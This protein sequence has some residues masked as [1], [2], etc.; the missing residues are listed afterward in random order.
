MKHL[1]EAYRDVTAAQAL[2]I[3][4]DAPS[5]VGAETPLTILPS[6]KH[7]A[8]VSTTRTSILQLPDE[9]LVAII[10]FVAKDLRSGSLDE[11]EECLY[12]WDT[13]LWNHHHLK[14]LSR[15]CRRFMRI[16]QPL[17]FRAI[18]FKSPGSPYE[19]APPSRSVRTLH[20]TL[21]ETPRFQ[22]YCRSLRIYIPDFDRSKTP[23]KY[24]VAS[25]FAHWLTRT[26]CLS[27]HGGFQ[28]SRQDRTCNASTWALIRSFVANCRDVEHLQLSR[29]SFGLYLDPIFKWLDF[30]NLNTLSVHGIS[31]WEHGKV[32][33]EPE[34]R[35]TAP[36]KSLI[37]S[38]YEEGPEATSLFIQWPAV[39]SH[40]Q[41]GSFYNNSHVMD[42]SMFESWLLIHKDTL[43]HVDIGYLSAKGSSGPFNATLFPNLEYLKL[44]R[45]QT[46]Q[47][48]VQFKADDANVLGPKLGTFCWGFGIFDQHSEGWLDF[49]EPE[50]SWIRDLVNA[51][52]ACK[53]V[54]RTVEIQF[55]PDQWDTDYG[56]IYPWDL[57]DRLGDEVL[58]PKGMNLVYNDPPISRENWLEK[59]QTRGREGIH[60]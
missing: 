7:G 35:R 58:R 48:S 19:T 59:L 56:M 43:K 45:W 20:H 33:L 27:I 44:S 41:F 39:L 21:K 51:A 23:H 38:D 6:Q 5:A 31:K 60:F 30:P 9:L 46:H 26:R 15:V 47:G 17:L 55:S 54:L 12:D 11:C 57:M 16:A 22:Q 50:S 3:V 52:V 40:F 28:N 13:R 29:E 2:T 34:K 4:H 25:D 37:L 42:Y 8:L 32:E 36:F 1:R 24:L 49:G 18:G 10:E 53:S 14:A